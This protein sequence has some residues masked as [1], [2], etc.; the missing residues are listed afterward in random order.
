MKITLLT[1]KTF[2][3]EQAFDFDIK[4]IKSSTAKR[5]TLRID[6]KDR[7]PVL[8]IPKRC[9]THKAVTF[10]NEHRGWIEKCLAQI[11]MS[12]CFQNQETISLLGKN[13]TICHAPQSRRGVYA[14]GN[15]LYVSGAAEFM[16]RRIC[17][18]I[19]KQAKQ[20]L[21]ELSQEKAAKIDC[22]VK[23]VIIKDTKS[24]WGSCSSLNNINYNWRIALAPDYVIE[25]LVAHEVSHLKHQ[26]HSRQFWQC[27]KNLYH[28]AGEGRLWLKLH[29]K[30]LYLYE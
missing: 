18:Y 2:D 10:V 5:L 27:V 21:F 30:E 20:K 24:R 11:P 15:I 23:N 1:G 28:R 12:R 17:D 4:I 29:G 26:D 14:E 19:K 9:S 25:Y 13:Y 6:A 7:I 3:I 8:S 22:H 16:H